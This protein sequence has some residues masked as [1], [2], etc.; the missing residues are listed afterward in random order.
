MSISD[1]DSCVGTTAVR[2]PLSPTHH[3]MFSDSTITE[4]GKSPNSFQ[5]ALSAMASPLPYGP[6]R[7][8]LSSNDKFTKGGQKLRR[9]ESPLNDAAPP[10]WWD[11]IVLF[12]DIWYHR[13]RTH[14][15]YFVAFLLASI[16][17]CS[18]AIGW[19]FR[20][21]TFNIADPDS[22]NNAVVSC[23]VALLLE[24]LSRHLIFNV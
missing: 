17:C 5:D 4:E 19:S 15:V 1:D 20:L 7:A 10:T 12:Y 23:L 6:P 8:A 24:R 14:W 21:R 22:V 2:P 11:K 16:V 13:L 3:R 18:I 9:E